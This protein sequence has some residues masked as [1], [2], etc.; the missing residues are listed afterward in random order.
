MRTVRASSSS[1]KIHGPRLHEF[2]A[3]ADGA[4]PNII[5]EEAAEADAALPDVHERHSNDAEQ[6]A[7][8]VALTMLRA[9]RRIINISS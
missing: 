5:L 7:K 4:T 2:D 6:H 1:P 8:V 3:A 9:L